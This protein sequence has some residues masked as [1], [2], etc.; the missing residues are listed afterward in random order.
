[1]NLYTTENAV[2]PVFG[3]LMEFRD[4]VGS[5][6]QLTT[7]FGYDDEDRVTS[8]TYPVGSVSN[9]YDSLGRFQGWVTTLGNHQQGQ[10]LSF[11]AGTG[12]N[13]TT[14]MVESVYS[15][16][17]VRG[18][19]YDSAGNLDHENVQ[20]SNGTFST[21]YYTYDAAGQLIGV[22]DNRAGVQRSWAFT[23][24]DGGNM[25]TRS[26][27]VGG[28]TTTT[29]FEHT[30]TSW[31]D[32]LTKVG[33]TNISHDDMGNLTDDGTWTYTWTRGRQLAGMAK[34]GTNT[35][36]AYT[37]DCAGLRRSKEVTENGVTKTV[38]YIR[39]GKY[40]THMTVGNDTLHF[41]YDA[42]NRPVFVDFNGTTYA[43]HYSLQGDVLGLYDNTGTLVVR[44]LYDAWGVR[45][46]CR[47]RWQIRWAKFSRSGIAGMSSIR[48]RGCII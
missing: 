46:G 22:V 9:I 25:L 28:V 16:L 3:H 21:I 20:E 35:S 42:L 43:Y 44:Y 12:T 6:A 19:Y 7:S 26:E 37:Y 13:G 27:T 23:Y 14:T 30:N 32:L 10:Y 39:N 45:W 8:I 31:Y 18:Y 29:T 33:T 47:G 48:R 34:T 15:T 41:Y 2:D 40:L 17:G 5:G 24:D 36:I 4:R 38:K 1:M 11:T